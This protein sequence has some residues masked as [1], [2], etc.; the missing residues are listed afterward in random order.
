MT[1][2]RRYVFDT[3]VLISAALF[4]ESTPG[5]ALRAALRGG[6]ILL[7]QATAEELHQVLGRPKFDRYVRPATRKRFLAALLRRAAL[8]EIDQSFQTCRD[9]RDDKFL[10]AAVSGHASFLISG[11]E[12]LL[13]LNPFHGIPIVTPAQFLAAAGGKPG[14]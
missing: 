2:E 4:K 1:E 9:P 13:A 10:E 14:G 6:S 11:D 8:V 3:G 7:W 5:Q 12:D